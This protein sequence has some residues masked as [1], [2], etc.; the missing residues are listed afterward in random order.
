MQRFQILSGQQLF[1]DV[2]CRSL[3]DACQSAFPTLYEIAERSDKDRLKT[4]QYVCSAIVDYL[5]FKNRKNTMTTNQIMQTAMLILE[6]YSFL[7]LDDLKLFVRR[8]KL[9]LYGE[10]YDL[11]GQVFIGW[12]NKYIEEKKHAQYQFNL[13]REREENERLEALHDLEL[14]KPEVLAAR[15]SFFDKMDKMFKKTNITIPS[16]P[17]TE[18]EKKDRICRKVINQHY[19]RLMKEYPNT[20]DDEIKKMIELEMKKYIKC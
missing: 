17:L 20:Y 7:K 10:V 2:V 9:N 18:E 13:K 4:L 19:A 3:D 6:E 1:N 14:S 5:D 16:S 15:Q 11:D 8:L 12:L